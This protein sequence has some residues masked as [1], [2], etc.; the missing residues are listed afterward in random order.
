[1][2]VIGSETVKFAHFFV[3]FVFGVVS[4]DVGVIRTF[5]SS[6]GVLCTPRN[7]VLTRC[8]VAFLQNPSLYRNRHVKRGSMRRARD[9]LAEIPDSEQ[10]T[11]TA[12]QSLLTE[13]CIVP[14]PLWNII[15]GAVVSTEWL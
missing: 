11:G 7:L 2:G 3:L 15:G 8:F 13:E 10:G 12:V 6:G 5:S 1:M 4:L 9:N 14:R